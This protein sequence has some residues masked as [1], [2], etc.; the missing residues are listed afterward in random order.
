MP[1]S[2]EHSVAGC[3]TGLS[4]MGILELISQSK[5]MQTNSSTRIDWG[6]VIVKSA[7]GAII[8]TIAVNIPDILEPATNPYHRQ[9]FHSKSVAILAFAGLCKVGLSKIDAGS[10]QLLVSFVAAYLIHL[11][12]DSKTELGLPIL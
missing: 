10:K 9:F 11:N 12:D 1:N 3:M 2:Y 5:A 8:G 6:T 7:V 4:L